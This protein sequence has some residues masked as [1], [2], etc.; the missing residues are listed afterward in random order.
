MAREVTLNYQ[1]G[2][3]HDT[4]NEV[5]LPG[6]DATV[7]HHLNDIGARGFYTRWAELM[8]EQP[9]SITVSA[10]APA[11]GRDHQTAKARHGHN[12]R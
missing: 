3:G 2:F 8:D 12:G 7:G 1:M 6:V 11:R 10:P 9:V 4:A 5:D